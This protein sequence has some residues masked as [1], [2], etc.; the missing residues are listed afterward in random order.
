MVE[1]AALAGAAPGTVDVSGKTIDVACVGG[2][3]LRLSRVQPPNKKAMDASAFA[4]GLRGR[5]IHVV[6]E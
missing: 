1:N 4:N 3:V 6:I 2:S 5:S